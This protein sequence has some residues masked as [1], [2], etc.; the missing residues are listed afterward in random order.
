ML[1]LPVMPPAT[2]HLP[3]AKLVEAANATFSWN[4]TSPFHGN[5]TSVIGLQTFYN[6]WSFPL[7]LSLDFSKN[8]S[9]GHNQAVEKRTSLGIF[10][11]LYSWFT[12]R[13]TSA[14][15]QRLACTIFHWLVI[16]PVVSLC[17]FARVIRPIQSRFCGLHYVSPV[18][19]RTVPGPVAL[20]LVVSEAIAP[21]LVSLNGF[22]PLRL[23]LVKPILEVCTGWFTCLWTRF[24]WHKI[25]S[26]ITVYSL[27]RR[28]VENVLLYV[29]CCL[30]RVY[31]STVQQPVEI[32]EN[33]SQNLFYKLPPQSIGST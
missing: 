1:L 31:C 29:L 19:G 3:L 23:R 6:I 14:I 5:G 32:S 27:G 8:L 11:V 4:R 20:C 21:I 2:I 24:C 18:L 22:V 12:D 9:L 10:W 13:Q 17:I 15:Q 16:I 25:M 7:P 30:L 28:L 26:S 33:I